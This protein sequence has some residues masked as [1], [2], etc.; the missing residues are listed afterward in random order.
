[1]PRS[2][3]STR[4][5]VATISS[6]RGSGSRSRRPRCPRRSS[7]RRPVG[8]V[9][10]L[11]A[12]SYERCAVTFAVVAAHRDCPARWHPDVHRRLHFRVCG[13]RVARVRVDLHDGCPMT[14]D[15]VSRWDLLSH[16]HPCPG[17]WRREPRGVNARPAVPALSVGRVMA[18]PNRRAT[19]TASRAL[20]SRGD[21]AGTG[22]LGH[23]LPVDMREALRIAP[24]GLHARVAQV[25][26]IATMCTNA[27]L[28][29]RDTASIARSQGESA[30]RCP[31][32]PLQVL[33]PRLARVADCR[34]RSGGSSMVTSGRGG[35][36]RG[37]GRR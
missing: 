3:R 15:D 8:H 31:R 1:M 27:V 19:L 13:T 14:V 29:W 26:P 32:L 12:L 18:P 33:Q 25:H 17:C 23:Q 35:L 11:G 22:R 30:S 7:R 4:E 5:C 28:D 16:A 20:R 6:V 37:A 34:R 9:D 10:D 2:R 36:E 21:G 24:V